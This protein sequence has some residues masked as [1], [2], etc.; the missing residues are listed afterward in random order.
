MPTAQRDRR[1]TYEALE[2]MPD[3]GYRREIVGGALIVTPTPS[4]GHQRAAGRLYGILLAS[5][6]PDTMVMP[7]PY[8]WVTEDGGSVQP[9]VLVIRRAD[10]DP[11]GPLRWPALPL[12]VVEVISPWK[13]RLDTGTKRELYESL[14]VAHYWMVDPEEPS[15]L[16]LALTDGRYDPEAHIQAS[17]AWETDHP[18]PVRVV[19]AELIR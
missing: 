5:E 7:A 9:D 17:V 3:D 8:D 13:P 15:L 6:T 12:L 19:P 18:F 14:G 16:A 1:F 2:E 11:K 4:G 10:F